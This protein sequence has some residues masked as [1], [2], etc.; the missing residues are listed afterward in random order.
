MEGFK[1][2]LAQLLCLA[3]LNS[4]SGICQL[5]WLLSA[6]FLIKS[7]SVGL[8]VDI[9]HSFWGNSL[10]DI[11]SRSAFDSKCLLLT[12]ARAE[13]CHRQ[14][15][16]KMV[17]IVI[18]E[19][20]LVSVNRLALIS[21]T[22]WKSALVTLSSKCSVKERRSCLMLDKAQIRILVYETHFV[23]QSAVFWGAFL[24]SWINYHYC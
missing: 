12:F 5:R 1:S 16:K 18:T 19:L 4:S 7:L 8:W 9:V 6:F 10:L 22:C 14:I 13:V 24:R 23:K 21:H 17:Y 15:I 20:Q 11:I 3:W 2:I